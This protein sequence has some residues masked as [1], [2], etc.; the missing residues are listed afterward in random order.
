VSLILL[1]FL[2]LCVNGQ[3]GDDHDNMDNMN[4]QMPDDMDPEQ[5]EELMKM[6][7][8]GMGGDSSDDE[9]DPGFGAAAEDIPEPELV[10]DS[11]V[12]KTE[13]LAPP[14]PESAV[15][16]ENFQ[17]E[18]E[19]R[20]EYS[21]KPMY[22]GRFELGGGR[23]PAIAGDRGLI[24]TA[25]AMHYGA[26]AMLDKPLST[27]DDG[28][29]VLQYELKLDAG[30]TCSGA[31]LKFPTSPFKDPKSFD[32]SVP[33]SVMFG[34]DKCGDT[35]KVHLI[36]QSKHPKTGA[37]TEHHLKD[38]ATP[39]AFGDE[40]HLYTA[41]IDIGASKYEVRIDGE[42]KKS[43][44]LAKD[45]EPPFQPAAEIADPKDSKPA[46]W[47]D[48]QQ[49][50]DMNAK[51]P[52]DWDEDAPATI[53]DMDAVMPEGWL[54]D[55][56]VEIPD[57]ASSKPDEWDEE[58]DGEWRPATILNP[59]CAAVGC[60]KWERPLIPNPAYKGKWIH[61]MIPNP[62]YIGEWSPRMIANPDYY[63]VDK[64]RLLDI[65]G[66]AIEIWAMDYAFIFDNIYVGTSVA[67]AEAYGNATAGLKRTLEAEKTKAEQLEEASAEP[68]ALKDKFLD[69]VEGVADVLEK[70]L[71]PVEKL[72]KDA[73]LDPYLNKAIDWSMAHPL[74]SSAILPLLLV[75]FFLLFTGKSKKPRTAVPETPAPE[76]T[77]TTE[78]KK[79]DET[80]KDDAPGSTEASSTSAEVMPA[81]D[82]SSTAR[83][84]STVQKRRTST[85]S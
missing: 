82:A 37:L 38:T 30:L 63:K 43:G 16:L 22:G 67:D 46:D 2:V 77:D 73:G 42:V 79:T 27:A 4:V 53:P 85:Y 54:E 57:P 66:V 72:V 36:I 28:V 1:G 76:T 10:V 59:K 48:A 39:Y 61:P 25:K 24:A 23:K 58:E 5:L 49:I 64:I 41:V 60:G 83:R 75:V 45:F 9:F 29:L 33:Y 44:S 26:V 65:V 20:W 40:T 81:A 15:F 3:Y 7:G 71:K 11:G 35:N 80:V 52:S 68:R 70:A 50:P 51:K 84:P 31:Y 8:G 17:G 78:A 74:V 55:E 69:G 18:F 62:D 19:D 32:S 34:P 56:P 12:D 6:Y 47:V 13:Y 14:A 21:Q